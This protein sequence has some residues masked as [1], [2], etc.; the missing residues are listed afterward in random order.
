M[1]TTPRSKKSTVHRELHLGSPELSGA[2]VKALQG[3]LNDVCKH[4]RFPWRRIQEDGEYGTRTQRCAKFCGWLIGLDDERLAV[5][6]SHAGTISTDLQRL[7]RDPKKRS[8]EDRER[9]DSRKDKRE[10]LHKA[11]AKGAKAAV[12]W[13]LKQVGKKESPADS[14]R[15]PGIDDWEAFFGLG[16]VP[17]CGCFAGY[18]VKKIGKANCDT[19]FPFAGS[20]RQDAIAGLN[21]LH[22]VNPADAEPG[23]IVTFFSGSDDHIGL[24]RKK[25]ADGKVFTVEGNTSSA[26]QDA[27]GGIV[28]IKEHS[29]GEVSCIARIEDWG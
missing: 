1:T 10:R 6:G 4:Y 23:D 28:E 17:W 21:N 12:A 20:I 13:A 26:T 29:L 7:L 9:E 25:S 24:I 5:I 19:W 22:D 27:D 16:A 3:R 14:N 18:A 11:H 2:D 15:G 8:P